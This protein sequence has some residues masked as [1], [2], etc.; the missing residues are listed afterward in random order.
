MNRKNVWVRYRFLLLF[1]LFVSVRYADAQA[2]ALLNYQG[3]ARNAAGVPLLNQNLSLRVNIRSGSSTGQVVYSETRSAQTNSYGLFSVQIGSAGASTS[4]GTLAAVNW[5]SGN[6]FMELEIDPAGGSSFVSLGTTQLLSVPYAL[7]ALT[8]SPAGAAGGD[9]SGTY[10][11]PTIANNAILTSK[12]GD[13][14]V[15]DSKI[16]GV[17]GSKVS[18]DITGN[19][20]NVTGIV[21]IA[22][23]GTGAATAAQAR[24]NLG[25]SN[26]SDSLRFKLNTADTAL[27]LAGYKRLNAP[28]SSKYKLNISDTASMLAAYKKI[29]APDSMRYKLNVADTA[30]M[31]LAYRRTGVKI[32]GGDLAVSYV[33]LTG[34]TLSGALNGT[35]IILSDTLTAGIIRKT[36]GSSS[37]Y[38]MAD[39]SVSAGVAPVREIA[40]EFTATAAQSVFTLSQ[41]PG[42]NSKVKMYINGIRISNTAYTVSGTV[43][44]YL[45]AN[46]GSYL[47]SVNDRIQFD[48]YY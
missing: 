47:L 15:T 30:S 33:P 18:G 32:P 42:P 34:G 2:P 13:L 20:G 26:T 22:N 16:A 3:V 48:Y 21:S 39:G 29:N 10:P 5:G 40:D 4:S 38:L 17:S 9:L 24:I 35:S 28:D 36:N 45:S 41:P 27:M 1:V 46:N 19:A 6:M 11:N 8:A 14:S 44:T 37:Q 23:G 7:S 12:L 31:L 43:L 25:I